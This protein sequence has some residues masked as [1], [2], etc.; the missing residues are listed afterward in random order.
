MEVFCK[1][2]YVD[3]HLNNKMI[4]CYREKRYT[5]VF[6]TEYEINNGLYMYIETECDISVFTKKDFDKYFTII[7]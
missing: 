4:K 3:I 2:S 5:S 1:R 6:P 7:K